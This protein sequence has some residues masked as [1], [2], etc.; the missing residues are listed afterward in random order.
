MGEHLR[1]P[2]QS[3]GG[4]GLLEWGGLTI[5][6]KPPHTALELLLSFWNLGALCCARS[7]RGV[8]TNRAVHALIR[9]CKTFAPSS[10]GNGLRRFRGAYQNQFLKNRSCARMGVR[11]TRSDDTPKLPFGSIGLVLL[12][13]ATFAVGVFAELTSP[14]SLLRFLFPTEMAQDG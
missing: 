2:L 14:E 6:A 12:V 5:Q 9:G 11:A 8:A 3:T 10:P 7:S 1:R 13:V 4:L